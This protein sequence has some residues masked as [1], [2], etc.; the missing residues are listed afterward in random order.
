MIYDYFI[1][2]IYIYC[3]Y[4]NIIVIFYCLF[5][6]YFF[7]QQE[8]FDNFLI[9]LM[10]KLRCCLKLGYM[11]YEDGFL[12]FCFQYIGKVFNILKS[13]FNVFF[14]FY[15]VLNVIICKY[16]R[17]I[18]SI[19]EERMDKLLIYFSILNFFLFID[20]DFKFLGKRFFFVGMFCV[21]II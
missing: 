10:L 2:I 5:Q 6:I 19:V 1:F 21:L 17:S 9:Q 20:Q 8:S 13:K 4:L 11:Y 14:L 15:I 16:V 12:V 18:Y 7:C 3:I